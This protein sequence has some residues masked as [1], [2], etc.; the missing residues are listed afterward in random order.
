M[1]VKNV[2][3]VSML[4]LYSVS[5]VEK[6]TIWYL[7]KIVN[8]L[9]GPRLGALDPSSLCLSFCLNIRDRQR[10]LHDSPNWSGLDASPAASIWS[11]I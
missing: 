4:N 6:K 11:V 5:Q 9:H 3:E 2:D 7:P 8:I 10:R 1:I